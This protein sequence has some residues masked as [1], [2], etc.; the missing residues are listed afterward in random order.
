[1]KSQ[2]AAEQLN[3]ILRSDVQGLADVIRDQLTKLSNEQVR[4]KVLSASGGG[5]TERDV[6]LAASSNAIIMGFNVRAN[7][8]VQEMAEL[9]KVDIRLHSILK[10]QDEIKAT[11]VHVLL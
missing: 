1:M 6:L 4:F 9:K 5:I 2:G 10:L 3:V 8:T 11:Q 7:R